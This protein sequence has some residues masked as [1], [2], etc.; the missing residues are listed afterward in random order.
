M[1]EKCINE[2]S[3]SSANKKIT[4]SIT[5]RKPLRILVQPKNNNNSTNTEV[6]SFTDIAFI[7]DKL[8]ISYEKTNILATAI[9]SCT[10]K[11]EIF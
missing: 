8:D 3:Q 2:E 9:R 4:L 11:Q 1:N 6:L 10:K 7:Q 5:R